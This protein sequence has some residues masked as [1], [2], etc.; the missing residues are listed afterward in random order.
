MKTTLTVVQLVDSGFLDFSSYYRCYDAGDNEYVVL[1]ARELSEPKII[2][3]DTI[4][5]YG[6]F[7]GV[8]EGMRMLTKEKV[9][10]P[11]VSAK[12]ID[13]LE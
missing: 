4:T 5:I 8:Q 12:Y 13:I 9:E 10:I 2:K 7:K 6:E 1:D 3:G 11:T